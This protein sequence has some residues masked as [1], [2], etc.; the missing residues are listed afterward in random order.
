MNPPSTQGP[1]IVHSSRGRLRIHLPDPDGRIAGR[2]RLLPGV[3]SAVATEL[4]GN[5]LILF[6]PR[7]T[8][9][10]TLLA[11]MHPWCANEPPAPA[12]HPD[13]PAVDGDPDPPIPGLY[14]TG[15]RGRVY[16]VL[17]WSSV[18]MAVVGAITPGIPTVPFV[19][20]ASYFFIRSS[21]SAHTWLRQSGWFGPLLRDWEEHHGVKRSVKIT[22]IGLMAAG[23]TFTWLMGLPAIVTASIVALELVGLVM[24]V[25]LPVV[26]PETPA[27]ALAAV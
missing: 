27:P 17:G 3:T 23:L 5:I 21:P 4:T 12:P 13:V 16:K 11:V 22:A 25:R 14:V 8:S 20:V 7:E 19:I 26:E 2:L 6:N 1:P 10:Q 18:G 9:E 15:A 24:V